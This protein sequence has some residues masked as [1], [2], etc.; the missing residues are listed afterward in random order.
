MLM[1]AH[2]PKISHVAMIIYNLVSNTVRQWISLPIW[3]SNLNTLQDS[4]SLYVYVL[5]FYVSGEKHASKIHL[6]QSGKIL[7]EILV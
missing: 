5:F 7:E 6:S 4:K 1:L 2:K 3:S